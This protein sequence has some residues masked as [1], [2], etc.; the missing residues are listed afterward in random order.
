[1]VCRQVP[2][3]AGQRGRDR[4]CVADLAAR[5]AAKISSIGRPQ[6]LKASRFS[7][8]SVY[9]TSNGSG[10][11]ASA[12]RHEIEHDGKLIRAYP[13]VSDKIT[14]RPYQNVCHR[15]LDFFSHHRTSAR[16]CR[17]IGV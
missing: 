4:I 8:S 12:R 11:G 6:A 1:M 2:Q 9:F 13:R 3:L 14:M 7:L 10:K 5:P 16:N 17:V 15:Y